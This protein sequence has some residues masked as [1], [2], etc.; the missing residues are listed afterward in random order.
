MC[1]RGQ[2]TYSFVGQSDGRRASLQK[3]SIEFGKSTVYDMSRK[4]FGFTRALSV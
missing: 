1:V 2:Y 3:K 4:N